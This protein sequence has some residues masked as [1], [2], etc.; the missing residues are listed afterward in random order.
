MLEK[1]AYSQSE[2]L[3]I[4]KFSQTSYMPLARDIQIYISLYRS[5]L[6]EMHLREHVLA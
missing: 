2:L 5:F 6:S 1:L 4:I 3:H